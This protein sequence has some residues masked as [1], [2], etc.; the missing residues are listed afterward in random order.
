MSKQPSVKKNFIYSTFYQILTLL[1][2][3]ITAPYVS[4]V[5]GAEG[6][7][8][9][10]YTNSLVTYFSMFAALGVL[11][12]GSREIAQHRDN[13][14]ER[15]KLFWE[16]ELLVIS[17]TII[18]TCGWLCLAI[19]Y[20]RY[21]L[22]LLILTIQVVGT[23]FD[24]SWFFGGLEQYSYIVVKNTVCK[25]ASIVLLFMFVKNK[26]DIWIYLLILAGSVV[27]GNI[28]TWT[29]LPSFLIKVEKKELCIKKHFKE[30]LIYFIPTIA[31]SVYTVL[32]KT[33]IGIITGSNSVNGYYENATKIVNMAKAIA[34]TSINS[35]LSSRI[36]YLF[37]N[38][39]VD[40]IHNRIDFALDYI[41]FMGVG[42]SL[43]II[44][45]AQQFVPWFFGE[46]FLET[47]P[48]LMT[49]SPIV[50]IVGISNCAGSLYYTPAGL[51]TTST[52]FIITG[53]VINLILN[54]I[55]IPRYSGYGAIV[56][57][58]AAELTITV[59]YIHN[60]NG[61]LTMSMVVAKIWKKI[62]ASIVML[63]VIWGI[64]KGKDAS[65]I[66]T[67]IQVIVGGAIYC[68]I[69]LVLK[70]KFLIN[71]FGMLKKKI[72]KR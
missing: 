5:L 36:S 28:S 62:I 39:K 4:R 31:T 8:I 41:L 44:G 42:I 24:I 63:F 13:A 60:S 7:G 19:F 52:K 65:I 22:Y 2:P 66:L 6:V 54:T 51:R 21:S 20:K 64:G 45:I 59:L 70:D 55:L 46:N 27:M 1:T 72:Q 25:L 11:S 16:I 43:G 53:S 10:S 38:K 67:V 9:Y 49:L 12:Y 3:L 26:N 61:F 18:A 30:T 50:V 48:M 34:F 57:S 56:A 29:Y 15:S 35:V 23:A 68:G 32:D 37:A 17:T 33:M 14:Y 69:L 71:C 58:L 47:I 40:E